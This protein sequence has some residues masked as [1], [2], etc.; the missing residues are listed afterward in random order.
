MQ[1]EWRKV[2]KEMKAKSP[3]KLAHLKAQTHTAGPAE[4]GC[5]YTPGR[6]SPQKPGDS[7]QVIP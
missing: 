7:N 6:A 4:L 5:S 1:K 3:S 2:V